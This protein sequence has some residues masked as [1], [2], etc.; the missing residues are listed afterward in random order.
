MALKPCSPPP[1]TRGGFC[2]PLFAP[3]KPPEQATRKSLKSLVFGGEQTP[4]QQPCFVRVFA[5]SPSIGGATPNR[6]NTKAPGGR[7]EE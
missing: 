4:E 1:R 5:P 6:P 7:C 3:N 2:S